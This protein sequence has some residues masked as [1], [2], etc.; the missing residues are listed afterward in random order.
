[1]KDLKAFASFLIC[2]DEEKIL[3]TENGFYKNPSSY[4]GQLRKTAG[5]P[6]TKPLSSVRL[7]KKEL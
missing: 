3:K 4:N 7:L 5:A 1:M 2:C 6:F